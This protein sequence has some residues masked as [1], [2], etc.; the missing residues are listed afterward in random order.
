MQGVGVVGLG[1]QHPEPQMDHARC[2]CL[3]GCNGTASSQQPILG[4]N[5]CIG[6]GG[7]QH[8]SPCTAPGAQSHAVGDADGCWQAVP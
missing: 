6:L 3:R 1:V 5:G 8:E 2:S 7:M 4:G